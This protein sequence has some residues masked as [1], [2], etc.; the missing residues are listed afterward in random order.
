MSLKIIFPLLMLWLCLPWVLCAQEVPGAPVPAAVAPANASATVG[1]NSLWSIMQDGGPLMW[2]I[3]ASSLL[4][5]VFVFERLLMLRR[6]R[7][8]PKMFVQKF[9][10][11]IKSGQLGRDAALELCDQNG[12]PVARVFAAAL[13][14]WGRPAVEVE[15]AVIDAGERVTHELRKYLRLFNGISSIAPLLG[16]LGTVLGMIS[17]FNAIVTGDAMG[18]AELLAG[19]IGEALITTAGGLFVAIPALI[20]YMFFQSRAE[21]LILE[22]DAA[23]QQVVDF[24]SAE[25]PEREA[26]A[27]ASAVKKSKAA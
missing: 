10:E 4:L 21:S 15:Q 18:R 14:K 7:V 26:L 25:S 3:L 27:K 9:L 19:G 11:Q 8:V 20:A 1:T 23:A 24:V 17:A 16:L 13:K 5:S 6:L 12:T 2:P 22:I